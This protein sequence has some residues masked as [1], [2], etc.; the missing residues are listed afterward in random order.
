M[1]L[2]YLFD[3]FLKRGIPL[4][5]IHT[6]TLKHTVIYDIQINNKINNKEFQKL[7]KKFKIIINSFK[8]LYPDGYYYAIM[9]L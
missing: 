3:G 2:E 6:F 5:Y 1:K 4:Y 9:Y 7:I 8:L